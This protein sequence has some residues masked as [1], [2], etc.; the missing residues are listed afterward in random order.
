MPRASAP[1]SSRTMLNVRW[2]GVSW[3]F[4]DPRP[5]TDAEP[6]VAG[7]PA[8]LERATGHIRNPR[9]GFVL[10]VSAAPFPGAS[11]EL[12]WLREDFGGHWYRWDEQGLEGWLCPALL[13]PFPDAPPKLYVRADPRSGGEAA[14]AAS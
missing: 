13:S 4:D 11:V 14:E 7:I 6:V 5:G 9:G 2:N 3:V 12:D 10:T 1:S 8:I